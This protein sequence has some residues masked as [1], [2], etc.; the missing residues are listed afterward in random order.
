MKS[1]KGQ[2]GAAFGLCGLL[3][4]PVIVGC[5]HPSVASPV[6]ERIMSPPATSPTGQPAPS[7]SAQLDAAAP[8]G[9]VAEEP[10]GSVVPSLEAVPGAPPAPV[11]T[12]QRPPADRVKSRPGEAEKI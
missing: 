3:W 4:L 10:G 5:G 1:L 2:A 8:D 12:G 6:G 11:A 9:R 7:E